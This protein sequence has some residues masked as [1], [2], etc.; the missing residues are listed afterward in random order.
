VA[1][2]S[3]TDMTPLEAI[4]VDHNAMEAP[5]LELVWGVFGGADRTQTRYH[6]ASSIL[7][8]IAIARAFE[9]I[10][11]CS[12]VGTPLFPIVVVSED[13]QFQYSREWGIRIPARHGL[14]LE[15]ARASWSE[16]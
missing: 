13:L 15:L 4:Y 16:G 8:S 1:H 10:P 6:P 3:V 14:P 11:H 5:S 7:L 9:L 12:T 2:I